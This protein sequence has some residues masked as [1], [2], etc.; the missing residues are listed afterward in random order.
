[1]LVK[2][3]AD[4][5]GVTSDTV[6][7]YTRIGILRPDKGGNGYHRFSM[8][9]RRVL[10]FCIRAKAL[11]FRLAEI[12]ELIEISDHGQSPCPAARRILSRNLDRLRKEIEE[13][14]RRLERM[15]QAAD[16]WRD[17]PD[18]APTGHEVCN[19]IKAWGSAEH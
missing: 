6:R 18:G 19:L 7:Y 4:Q 1:M 11:G 5:L 17:M 8:K 12:H 14:R 9:D 10:E 13:S 3:I 16:A 2:Q 15:E